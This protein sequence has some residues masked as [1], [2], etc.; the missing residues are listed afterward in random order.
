MKRSKMDTKRYPYLALS[1]AIAWLV[2]STV[3]SAAEGQGP[4]EVEDLQITILSTMLAERGIGEWG[5][6]ALIEADGHRIL[7]D[8]GRYPDTVLRNAEVMGIDLSGVDELVLSHNHSDHTGGLVS[9]R[10]ALMAKN[11]DA[12]SRVHV[13]RGIFWQRLGRPDSYV[14]MET[15]RRQYVALGGTVVEHDS[16]TE[17][18][19]GIWLTGP[20]PRVHPERN[21]GGGGGSPTRPVLSPDGPVEDNI[22]ESMSLVINTAKGLVVV[23]GCGHA[24]IINTLEYAQNVVRPVQIHA[25]IGGFHLAAASDATLEWTAGKLVDI[26]VENFVGAHCTGLEPVYRFRQLVDLG[27]ERAAVGAVGATFSLADGLDPLRIAR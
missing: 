25:A 16:A 23:S 20:V 6:A 27:R 5:F 24:G 17:I 15:R 7:F 21:W 18:H 22:P 11:P 1:A 9:M 3:G 14:Q 19:P 10:K 26:G 13:A 4:H 12:L 2:V 8:T